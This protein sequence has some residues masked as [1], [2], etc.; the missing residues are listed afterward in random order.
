MHERAE[1][2]LREKAKPSTQVMP[3][4]LAMAQ[5]PL[6]EPEPWRCL[7]DMPSRLLG[8]ALFYNNHSP[9]LKTE[10]RRRRCVL[11]VMYY[12]ASGMQVGLCKTAIIQTN[13]QKERQQ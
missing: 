6:V 10:A 4:S 2:D 3:R 9:Y 5:Q 1:F 12:G 11:G 7:E 13:K 8:I